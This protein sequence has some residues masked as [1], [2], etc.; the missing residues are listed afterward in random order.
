MVKN[1]LFDLDGT[2]LV[3]KS[4][5]AFVKMYLE[6]LCKRFCPTLGVTPQDLSAAIFDATEK[7]FLN[8]GGK[9]N[10]EVFWDS[11]SKNLGGNLQNKEAEFDDFYNREFI[12][13][14][15]STG[16][17]PCS[18]RAVKCLKSKGYRLVLATNPVFPPAAT[19]NRI[20]WAGISPEYFE[21]ITVY[22]NSS[23]CKPNTD[24]YGEIM[25][26]L[27][28][29]PEECLMVGN[30]VDEDMCTQKIGMETYLVTDCLENK[31]NRDYSRFRQGTMEE[32]CGFAEGMPPILR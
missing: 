32:F 19:E 20:K 28:M 2:L 17:N 18:A 23:F 11:F 16:V 13:A 26:K 29:L 30:D 1:V 24:Y 7:M 22:N 31:N 12:Y 6:A 5:K 21:H 14:K 15:Q 10:R 27:N 8:D 3:M 9:T 4:Q 25:Q